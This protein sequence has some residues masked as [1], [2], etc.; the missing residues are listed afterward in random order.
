VSASIS[1]WVA[2]VARV[3]VIVSLL[4]FSSSLL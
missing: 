3:S 2:V 4:S 1:A